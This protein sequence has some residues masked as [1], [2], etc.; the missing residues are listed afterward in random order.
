[1]LKDL[2]EMKT[3]INWN[4]FGDYGKNLEKL[5]DVKKEKEKRKSE[6]FIVKEAITSLDNH[7]NL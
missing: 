2:A 6:T 3:R 5:S 4:S 1:M 7:C